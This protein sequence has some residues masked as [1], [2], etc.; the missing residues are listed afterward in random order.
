[1]DKISRQNFIISMRLINFYRL[2]RSSYRAAGRARHEIAFAFHAC[3]TVHGKDA[4]EVR[5]EIGERDQPRS[6]DRRPTRRTPI[7]TSLLVMSSV[8]ISSRYFCLL[9]P[10]EI[11]SVSRIRRKKKVYRSRRRVGSL[12]RPVSLDVGFLP[13]ENDRRGERCEGNDRSRMS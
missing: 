8:R 12:R 2:G 3:R 4:S 10:H 5:P 6:A 9:H 7:R 11:A 13:T 1:M